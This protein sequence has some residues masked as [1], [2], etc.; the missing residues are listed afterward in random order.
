MAITKLLIWCADDITKITEY[1][2]SEKISGSLIITEVPGY[3]QIKCKV[4]QGLLNDPLLAKCCG[5]SFC[6]QC[7]ELPQNDG[8][9][10]C[11]QKPLNTEEDIKTHN[12]LNNIKIKCPYHVKCSWAGCASSLEEHLTTC[13]HKCIPCPKCKVNRERQNIEA[14]LKNECHLR[15]EKCH[16]CKEEVN[17]K[18]MSAHVESCPC[19]PLVCPN[20]CTLFSKILRK[21]MIGHLQVCPLQKV[22]CDFF[23]F[24]CNAEIKRRQLYNHNNTNMGNHLELLA[25]AVSKRDKKIADLEEKIVNLETKLKNKNI[26]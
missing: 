16:Y 7:L 12:I 15:P 11:C 19:V 20:N 3:I 6:R 10:H 25:K 5:Q 26:T 13:R 9:P 4:C 1:P 23:E 18:N 21:E 2:I 17:H 22:P 14:H 24:G 8:C